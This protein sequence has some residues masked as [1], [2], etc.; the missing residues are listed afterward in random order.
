MAK[1]EAEQIYVYG[2]VEDLR[3]GA[4]GL[5]LLVG[6]AESA[7][8]LRSR[9]KAGLRN[10]RPV[11]PCSRVRGI[12][13]P[14]GPAP[15]GRCAADALRHGPVADAPGP[16]GGS[17]PARCCGMASRPEWLRAIPSLPVGP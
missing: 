3:K 13:S 10:I 14:S 11:A 7:W 8:A 5:R 6:Q 12:R 17:S 16:P 1:I 2:C 9:A 4:D 15:V